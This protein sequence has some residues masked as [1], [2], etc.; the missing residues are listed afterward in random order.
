MSNFD[1]NNPTKEY[2]KTILKGIGEKE[3]IKFNKPNRC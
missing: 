2:V 1:F 3:N